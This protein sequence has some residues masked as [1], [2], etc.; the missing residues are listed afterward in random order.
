MPHSHAG[1]RIANSKTEVVG[2]VRNE[3]GVGDFSQNHDRNPAIPAV[4]TSWASAFLG[5]RANVTGATVWYKQCK[6]ISVSEQNMN[7]LAVEN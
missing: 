7:E 6:R 1:E 5:L 2:L 4:F 3:P